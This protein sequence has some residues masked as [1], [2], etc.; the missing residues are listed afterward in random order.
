[1]INKQYKPLREALSIHDGLQRNVKFAQQ[2][3]RQFEEKMIEQ[4]A[5]YPVGAIIPTTGFTHKGKEF[6]VES[7]HFR[8]HLGHRCITYRGKIMKKDG[9]P[10]TQRGE[11]TEWLEE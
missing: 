3:K 2:Q 9:T 1:M 5:S 6:L 8:D 7:I 10:G 11:A 4:F